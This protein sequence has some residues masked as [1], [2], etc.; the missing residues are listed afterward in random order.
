MRSGRDTLACAA[1]RAH[2]KAARLG[3]LASHASRSYGPVRTSAARYRPRMSTDAKVFT[4]PHHPAGLAAPQADECQEC[5][6]RVNLRMCASCGHV[7]CCE[8]QAG[9]ARAHALGGGP[10]THY[11]LR[12]GGGCAPR[13]TPLLIWPPA[14]PRFSTRILPQSSQA[15]GCATNETPA[16]T[17]VVPTATAIARHSRRRAN[18]SRPTPGDEIGR[19]HG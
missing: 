2:R 3:S 15:A 4:C 1:M 9:H 16:I 13:A 11:F 8:S 14:T 17:A 19:A 5:G 18:Q 10:P 12:G 6:S 7:G